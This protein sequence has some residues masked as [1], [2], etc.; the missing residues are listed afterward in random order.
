MEA[1]H[2]LFLKEHEDEGHHE[3]GLIADEHEPEHSHDEEHD[4]EEGEYA[5]DDV[6][7]FACNSGCH[8]RQGAHDAIHEED[9]EEQAEQSKAPPMN[10][11]EDWVEAA[12]RLLCRTHLPQH[13]LC[14][15][16]AEERAEEERKRR[17]AEDLAAQELRADEARKRLEEE[18][19]KFLAVSVAAL[20]PR[21]SRCAASRG[22]EAQG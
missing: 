14:A 7:P 2:A 13:D 16:Q 20:L 12:K 9:D 15:G 18:E 17:E 4:H 1:A 10:L 19:T 8:N 21:Q 6:G 3:E 22:A 11:P 5:H